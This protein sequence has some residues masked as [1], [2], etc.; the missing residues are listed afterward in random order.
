MA[1]YRTSRKMRL[2]CRPR[3]TNEFLV[4]PDGKQRIGDQGFGRYDLNMIGAKSHAIH[5]A[6]KAPRKKLGAGQHGWHGCALINGSKD[7]FQ[8]ILLC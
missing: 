2:E 1:D 6:I 7:R 8:G 5:D 3:V 4:V